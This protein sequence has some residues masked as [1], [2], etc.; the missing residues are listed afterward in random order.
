MEMNSFVKIKGKARVGVVL[1]FSLFFIALL[2]SVSP[3]W[4]G[5]GRRA[6]INNQLAMAKPVETVGNYYF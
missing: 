1:L 4:T 5:L 3:G 6:E 2:W